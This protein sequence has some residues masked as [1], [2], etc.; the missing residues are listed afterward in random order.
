MEVNK[1]GDYLVLPIELYGNF[2]KVN[3][4][5]SKVRARIFYKYLNRNRTFITDDFAALLI[6]SLSYVPIKGIYD[7]PKN[8]GDFDD[9]GKARSEGRIYGLVPENPNFAWEDHVDEDGVTR[10]YCCAD[11]YLY[12]GLYEESKI[13]AD[14]SLSMEL[15]PPTL[16]AEWMIYNGVKVLK[17]ISGELLGLQVLGNKYEPCFEG[18]EFY[19]L[20]TLL[21]KLEKET[22]EILENSNFT[23]KGG[24]GTVKLVFELSDDNKWS[25]LWKQLNPRN[26]EADGYVVNYW[27]TAVYDDRVVYQDR[28]TMKY[29][30]SSYTVNADD[31]VTLGEAEPC[32]IIDINESE[33]NALQTI[34]ALNSDTFDNIDSNYQQLQTDKEALDGTVNTLNTTVEGLNGQ[35]TTLNEQVSTYT[36]QVETLTQESQT[37]QTTI[38]SLTAEIGTLNQ[39]KKEKED[40]EKQLLL[41]KY[42][43]VLSEEVISTY[44]AALDTYTVEDLNAKLSIAYVKNTPSIFEKA[45]EGGT[46]LPLDN[47]AYTGVDLLLNQYLTGKKGGNR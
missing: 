2:E 27:I 41:A 42:A 28:E 12:T 9:H 17:Y 5:I 40:N 7:S 1:A 19:S 38:D 15:Y 37:R 36:T 20:H 22:N 26:N 24:N 46:A 34:R 25:L 6:K 23:I 18:A 32:M 43:K 3:N 16:T 33:Y 14:K 39:F 10:N 13:I 30:R 31:T 4:L 47:P 35:I 44:S 21:E 45:P 11:V 29:F 8:P